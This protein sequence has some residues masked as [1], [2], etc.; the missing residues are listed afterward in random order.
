MTSEDTKAL[1][2]QRRRG[3]VL[4]ADVQDLAELRT[5]SEIASR[6]PETVGI[7][8]GF[9]LALRFGLPAVVAAVRDAS[10]VPVVYDHQKAGTD[11]P[12]MGAAF[13]DVCRDAGAH[14]MI[15]FPQ[16]GPKTLA[17][18]VAEARDCGLVPIVGLVMTHAAYLASE[19]G[20]ITDD[21][22][23]E[24]CKAA[25]E[26]GVTNFV[27]PGTKPAV[28][29]EF[30]TGQ[31]ARLDDAT[32]MMPGIG[33]QGGDIATAFA[34]ASPHRKLAIIGSA[35]YGAPDPAEALRGFAREL[36]DG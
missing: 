20:Y 15:L 22:P 16:A 21:A 8:V 4:A 34:A 31:L 35:V 25:I 33:R 23:T 27:L 1:L 18:F 28:V 32:V 9:S 30:A 12:R 6:V 10:D 36:E 29:R 2:T 7:K 3:I 13:A 11:I 26:M 5:L 17:S 19:G 24:T 14:G